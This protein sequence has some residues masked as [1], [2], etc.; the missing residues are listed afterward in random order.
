MIR[1]KKSSGML[2]SGEETQKLKKSVEKYFGDQVI[3]K[4]G[5]DEV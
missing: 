1:L 5:D 2:S 4:A 3:R